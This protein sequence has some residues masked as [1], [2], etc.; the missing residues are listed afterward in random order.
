MKTNKM[1]IKEKDIKLF[2][3]RAGW[4]SAT[5]TPLAVDASF[6]NYQ[7]LTKDGT[8]AI[9]MLAPPK[10]EGTE[11]FIA[12]DKY[13]LASGFSVPAIKAMDTKTGLL[14][15]EDFGDKL[16]KT[17]MEES[18]DREFEYYS[19]AVELLVTLQQSK[20]PLE[21]TVTGE[22]IHKLPTYDNDLL[23]KEAALFN[24]WYLTKGLGVEPAEHEQSFEKVWGQIFKHLD[25]P[26]VLTLRD[27]HAENIMVLLERKHLKKI[28]LL[29]FQDAIIGHR[30]YDMVSLL[31]DA[32]RV[33]S[34]ELEEKMIEHYLN[35]LDQKG[36][37][38]NRSLFRQEYN[39]LGAQRNAKIIGI[40]TRL[41]K[42]DKKNTYAKMTPHVWDML[43][44]NLEHP[45]LKPLKTLLDKLV[46]TDQRQKPMKGQ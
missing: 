33:V 44:R 42:R 37:K 19:L 23:M 20:P 7:R 31:Q 1:T 39:I 29:D 8:T 25:K 35:L 15:L 43:E 9:L 45:N 6:R 2:L 17:Q 12:I 38:I 10:K 11:P 3:T 16:L 14:I 21:L 28:G 30:A 36:F 5:R 32:R 41:W 26:S 34:P 27:Y 4:A 46:P 24:E 18:V 40:F 22:K 13:L